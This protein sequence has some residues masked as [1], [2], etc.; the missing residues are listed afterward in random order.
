[1]ANVW[2]SLRAYI[3]YA[4]KQTIYSEASYRVLDYV[5][6]KNKLS[7]MYRICNCKNKRTSSAF[8]GK[9]II[10]GTLHALGPF[11]LVTKFTNITYSCSCT[12]YI[13]LLAQQIILLI[14]IPK[15][16]C[17]VRTQCPKIIFHSE[18]THCLLINGIVIYNIF[19]TY[20][21]PTR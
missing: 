13:I 5:L 17:F 1:M 9:K 7:T 2:V 15:G 21:L 16:T 10:Q 11:F 20:V 8:N 12:S 19:V 4:Y 14:H 6:R 18:D 3:Y